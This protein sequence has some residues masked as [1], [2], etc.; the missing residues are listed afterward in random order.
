MD[1]EQELNILTPITYEEVQEHIRDGLDFEQHGEW[2]EAIIAFQTAVDLLD[3]IAS[4]PSHLGRANLSEQEKELGVD[5]LMG[6]LRCRLAMER[7]QEPEIRVAVIPRVTEVEVRTTV[8]TIMKFEIKNHRLVWNKLLVDFRKQEAQYREA[9]MP[10]SAE[11]F[12]HWGQVSQMNLYSALLR[13]QSKPFQ[14]PQ[15]TR[16]SQDDY[17]NRLERRKRQRNEARLYYFK[18]LLGMK[19]YYYITDFR[20]SIRIPFIR[21]VIYTWL[22]FGLVYL[23]AMPDIILNG[24]PVTN[25]NIIQQ[26]I[27]AISFSIFNFTGAGPGDITL[28]P[29]AYIHFL[30]AVEVGW[31]YFVTVI[32]ISRF[33]NF[34]TNL[35][36]SG[37]GNGRTSK[38][39]STLSGDEPGQE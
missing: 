8:A 30:A 3:Q 6:I 9:D 10:E 26:F 20:T 31:G 35:T 18:K 21:L 39:G 29:K 4:S 24:Q 1:I 36:S 5:G 17:R 37:T 11:I 22:L 15:R 28:Q 14:M 27:Y 32:I 33:I 2:G 16:E 23:I 7:S 34:L 12:Y 25:A 19:F 38:K 13:E